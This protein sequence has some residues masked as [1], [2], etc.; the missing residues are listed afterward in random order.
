MRR[1]WASRWLE[2]GDTRAARFYFLQAY[3]SNKY[4]PLAFS[5]LAELA[6]GEIG[7]AVYFEHLRLIVREKPL[8]MDAVMNLAQY[9]E[10]LM[11]YQVAAGTYRY[12]ADLFQYL[13][14]DQPLPSNIYLPWAIA[15]YNTPDQQALCLEIAAY[16]RGQGRF[17]LL[18]EAMAGRAAAQMGREEEARQIL[19][20]A[21]QRALQF[22]Q[23]GA[24]Q[25]VMGEGG[26][27]STARA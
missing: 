2:Q 25:V 3:K 16:V 8:D 14:S 22:L 11:L 19:T 20:Q 5:K 10:R 21:E 12:A 6:P 23:V 1:C 18:L 7:P 26:V 27:A 4:N 24:G 9:A 13:H 17:D 15:C